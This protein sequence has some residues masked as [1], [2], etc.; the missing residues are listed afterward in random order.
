MKKYRE[1]IIG[2]GILLVG[3]FVGICVAIFVVENNFHSNASNDGWLGF[4]G[5]LFGSFVSGMITFYILYINRKDADEAFEKN[6]K[7]ID[8][9]QSENRNEFHKNM[10]QQ[11]AILKYQCNIKICDD[12]MHLVAELIKIAEDYYVNVADN[13]YG[14]FAEKRS[15]TSEICSILEMKLSDVEGSAD[16]VTQAKCYQQIFVECKRTYKEKKEKSD[17]IQQYSE[18]VRQMAIEL[19]SNMLATDDL[20]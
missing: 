11:S 16:F 13:T 6:K 18:G 12:V 14:Y 19:C 3:F 2:L 20:Y 9:I 17:E 1:I 15:R 10:K 4:F 8:D 5:G 7:Q